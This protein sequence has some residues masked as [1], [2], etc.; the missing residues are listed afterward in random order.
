MELRSTPIQCPLC[1]N[2]HFEGVDALR[3]TLVAVATSLLKCPVCVETVVG[4]DK[5]TIHLFAHVASEEQGN[6]KDA[7]VDGVPVPNDSQQIIAEEIDKS[8]D[9]IQ[10]TELTSIPSCNTEDD[11]QQKPED[12]EVV[13]CDI[14]NFCFTDKN[15]LDMHQKLLHQTSPDKKGVYSYHCHLCSKKFKMRGSLMVHLRVAHYGFWS[16][17]AESTESIAEP[18]ESKKSEDKNGTIEESKNAQTTTKVLDNK[19]WECDVCSKMFTT[20]YFLKKHKRLHTGNFVIEH[21]N[22]FLGN[23]V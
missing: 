17:N 9:R 13:R 23:T 11:L 19:Q 3:A 2:P 5:L 20:K 4:L 12:L 6:K 8:I 22:L 18:V 14:C 7:V 16:N 21:N 15:I 1:L 10:S